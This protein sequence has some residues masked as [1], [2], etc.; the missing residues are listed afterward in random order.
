MEVSS[1]Q[2]PPSFRKTF[3]EAGIV[4]PMKV[5]WLR[6]TFLFKKTTVLLRLYQWPGLYPDEG[7]VAKA[8]LP[9]E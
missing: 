9:Y 1:G 8:H 6:P 5:S 7:F 3:M 4:I 2:G